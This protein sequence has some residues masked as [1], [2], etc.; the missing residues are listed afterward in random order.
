MG[1]K[2][3]IDDQELARL[4]DHYLAE[5]CDSNA[6]RF[7]YTD[8]AEFARGKGY[9]GV[10][11]RLLRRSLVVRSR[12]AEWKAATSDGD[13]GFSIAYQSL[14][15]DEFMHRNSTREAMR[16]S[17]SELDTYYHAICTEA[18]KLAMENRELKK[19][20]EEMR[21][22]KD[23]EQP[24]RCKEPKDVREN[25]DIPRMKEQY[26]ALLKLVE[27]YVYPE[28]ANELLKKK[29][30]LKET[31]GIVNPAAVKDGLLHADT[32][33]SRFSEK[34]NASARSGS[35]VIMDLF[36]RFPEGGT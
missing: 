3:M 9:A 18:A 14:D 2:K 23:Q 24:E 7:K 36:K 6:G 27:T 8:M 20:L 17:L 4:T 28:I 21:R 16:S 29:G 19:R 11:D 15:I 1:R 30:L 26:H 5:V 25:T 12:V 33:L 10:T 32:D 31:S 13:A 35:A 22:Q 34:R